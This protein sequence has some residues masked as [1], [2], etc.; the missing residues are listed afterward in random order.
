MNGIQNL[1]VLYRNFGWNE[2]ESLKTIGGFSIQPNGFQGKQF[3]IGK[4]GLEMWLKTSF[5]KKITVKVLIPNEYITTGNEKYLFLEDVPMIDQ[6]P[7]GTI[8]GGNLEILNKNMII[9]WF[10]Y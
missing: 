6:H 9:E 4:S 7:G 2:Y 1:T 10:Q 8:I 3:W 5:S